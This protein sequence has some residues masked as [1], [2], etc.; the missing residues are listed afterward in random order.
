M[1]PI[2]DAQLFLKAMMLGV[3]DEVYLIDASTMQ[4]VYMSESA[5]EKTGLDIDSFKR[6]SIDSMLGV[7]K[8]VLETQV[9]HSRSQAHFV[10]M[11]LDH[12]SVIG[13]AD[14]YQLRVMLMQLG[15][16]EYVL[17]IKND[18][19][20]NEKVV[21]ALNESE[22]RFQALVANTPGLVCQF[23]ADS[24]GEISFVYL[25][26]GCKALLGLEPE[27]LRQDSKL[28]YAMMNARDHVKLR[29]RI[30]ASAAVVK[31]LDWE[32]RVWID[33]WQDTKWINLRATPRVFSSGV[34]QWDGIML[35]VTQSKNERLEIEKSRHDLAALTEHINKIKEQER[36]KIAREIHD[37]LG[38]NLTAIKMGLTSITSQLKEDQK[39][40]K[41]KTKILES[42]V[43][44]TFETVHRI[45]GNLRPN[46]LDLGIV[47]AIEWQ[48]KEFEKKLAITCVFN[49]N[50]TEITTATDQAIALFRICQEA[51]SN[52]AKYAHATQVNVDLIASANEVA[53]TISDNGIGIKSDDKLKTDSFGLRGMQERAIA[54]HGS[55]RISKPTADKQGTVITVKLPI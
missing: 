27:V 28:L 3:S 55:F 14:N 52:I 7:S 16:K 42:I 19:S 13:S 2:A 12:G 20:S 5:R 22:S 29:T 35:N 32:G 50:Q 45:S 9:K 51:M 44:N 24:D 6:E 41:E 38:G 54:L 1:F 53:L 26:N 25:S 10:E 43:D 46:I 23:Q 49:C 21:H 40:L 18:L 31:P 34:I 36:T 48:V 8:K 33:G 11:S 39:N 30:K 4:M 37:D 47:D 17:I 15:E